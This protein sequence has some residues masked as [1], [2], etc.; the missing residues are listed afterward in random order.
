MDA[1]LV[2]EHLCG[3]QEIAK[4]FRVSQNTVRDWIE[5]GLP[6]LFIGNKWQAR[7]TEIW[8]WLKTNQ[9]TKPVK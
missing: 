9:K 8:D 2:P 3:V 6:C 5:A 1:R 7:Y 4:A